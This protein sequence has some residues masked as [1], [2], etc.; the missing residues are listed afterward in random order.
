M[1]KLQQLRKEAV[2]RHEKLLT[3]IDTYAAV[4]NPILE[5][6]EK[7]DPQRVD[8][9]DGYTNLNIIGD[10]HKLNAIFGIL[11]RHGYAPD[12]RPKAGQSSYC[13]FFRRSDS[14]SEPTIWLSFSSTQ[15][16]RV[17]TGTVTRTVTEDVYETV[18]D[19][20]EFP[21]QTKAD[22]EAA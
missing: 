10:K 3:Y 6:V 15:C 7:L 13:E 9:D 11:R 21:E 8:V 4:L 14:E 22:T 19:E 20:Q 5:E 17:K 2:E 1:S 16:R 12:H 18:C